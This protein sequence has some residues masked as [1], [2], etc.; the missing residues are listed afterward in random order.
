[1]N[2]NN[3]FIFD[4]DGTL[5]RLHPIWEKTYNSLYQDR[6]GFTLTE[7]EMKSMFGPPE[8]ECHTNILKGRGMYNWVQAHALVSETEKTMLATLASTNVR[9]YTIPGARECLQELHQTRAALACA[10]GNI[11]SIAKKILARA[12]LQDYFPVVSYSTVETVS[13]T[14]IVERAKKELEQHYQREFEPTHTYVIGDTP[15]DVRAA[16][17]LGYK[18]IAVA[19]GNYWARDLALCEPDKLILDLRSLLHEIS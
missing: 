17:E 10:T 18:A 5:V 4:I 7:A 6:Y 13:R 8:L 1:M 9:N 12:E 2:N 19:T 11:E 3:A 14:Q 16:R 15:M